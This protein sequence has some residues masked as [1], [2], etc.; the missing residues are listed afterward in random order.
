MGCYFHQQWEEGPVADKRVRQAMNLAINREELVKFI[1]AGQAKPI[2]MYPIGSFAVTAGADT[3]L[4]PYPY[5]PDKAKQLLKEAGYA[6]GFETTIYSYVRE[7]VPEMA[8]LV[9]ALAGYMAKIGVK[10]SIFATEYP[11][12]RTRRMTG[13]MPGH[14]SC[15]GTPNRANAGDLLGLLHALHH[16]SSRFSDHHVPE[17]D[18][19]I[20]KATAATSVEEVKELIGEIHRWMYNDYGTMPLAEVSTPFVADGKKIAR[21]DL[22]RTL[23]DNND[24]DLI[25]R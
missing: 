1:F 9:E 19:M 17:L 12:A 7:D 6:N 5:D 10:L 8:R 25:R 2:A 3:S 23:Y 14:I 20:E 21:W 16:S 22:G 11:V 24:R 15:L 13:K 18:A 4:Q